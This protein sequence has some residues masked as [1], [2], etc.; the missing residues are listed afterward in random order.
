MGEEGVS[1][2]KRHNVISIAI[3]TASKVALYD[4]FEGPLALLNG[5]FMAKLNHYL[6]KYK[7]KNIGNWHDR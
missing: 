2:G 5:Q 7:S 4:C 3:N 6:I 1:G